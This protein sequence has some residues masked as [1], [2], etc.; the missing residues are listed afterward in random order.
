MKGEE[1]GQDVS[2][3]IDLYPNRSRDPFQT[4]PITPNQLSTN[5]R[6]IK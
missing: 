2:K 3:R 4:L 5:G 6:D 1:K